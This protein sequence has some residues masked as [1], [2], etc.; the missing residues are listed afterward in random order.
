MTDS[1][2]GA[3]YEPDKKVAPPPFFEEA[4]ASSSSSQQHPPPAPQVIAAPPI[5]TY[6]QQQQ[7]VPAVVMDHERLLQWQQETNSRARR[8]FLEA[9]LYAFLIYIVLALITGMTI[10]AAVGEDP[11]KHR[12]RHGRHDPSPPAHLP[13]HWPPREG[14]DWASSVLRF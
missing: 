5:S 9:L 12:H 7:Q 8:R 4:T 10:E 1:K 6:S 3:A 13:P 11:G 14:S 2:P